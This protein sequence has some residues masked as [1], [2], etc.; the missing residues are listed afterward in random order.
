MSNVGQVTAEDGQRE[1]LM[2]G[3]KVVD[4]ARP[5]QRSL[6]SSAKP[7]VVYNSL[8]RDESK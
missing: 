4:I 2:E 1:R 8:E 7:L 6:I 5:Q 3:K